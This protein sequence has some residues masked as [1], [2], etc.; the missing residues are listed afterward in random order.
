MVDRRE[1]MLESRGRSR[2][3][4][5]SVGRDRGPAPWRQRRIA[6]GLIALVVLGHLTES[7]AVRTH[8]EEDDDECRT[9][10]GARG[11]RDV[12][13][14]LSAGSW[15]VRNDGL[16][17]DYRRCTRFVLSASSRSS[18]GEELMD[19][20]SRRPAGNGARRARLLS[21]SSGSTPWKPYARS[22]RWPP[23]GLFLSSGIFEIPSR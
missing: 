23:S 16:S 10:R 21:S 14:L 7:P 12:V 13:D 1:G 6:T 18:R 15:L 22:R 5:I 17:R 3:A 4:H 8:S 11:G 20:Q 9:A 2:E 19:S